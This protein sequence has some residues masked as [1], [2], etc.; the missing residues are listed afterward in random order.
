MS[1]AP[2]PPGS[3]DDA[4]DAYV[5]LDE[6]AARARAE[7]AGWT[8]VRTL[9]PGAIITMEYVVGRINFTVGDGRVERA[10]VG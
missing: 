4:M 1:H 3:P 10:W 9:P 8:H 6:A 2:H 7:A 5:G